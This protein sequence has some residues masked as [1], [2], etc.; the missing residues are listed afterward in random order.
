MPRPYAQQVCDLFGQLGTRGVSILAASGDAGPGQS[1]QSNNG[2][3]AVRFLPAFPASCPWV[4]TVGATEGNSP[5]VAAA[6][7]GGGFSD[8]FARPAYQYDAVEAYLE[9]HGKE[10]E[11]Y[12]NRSGRAF[13]DV[14][15]LGKNYPIFNHDV[16][17]SADG[18][19]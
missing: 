13:P 9:K 5:E 17:E 14:A 7:S 2:S 19:R 15:A 18:T 16:I 10:W 6:L 4:T 3:E 12:Y 8:Y 1:C 11:G